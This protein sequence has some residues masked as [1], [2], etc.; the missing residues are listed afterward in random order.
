[1]Q[2]RTEIDGLRALAV[3]PVIFFHAGFN[4]F[5]GGF[6]GV[7]IFFVIS[8]YL[9]TNIILADIKDGKF[10]VVAFY[11][12]RARRILPAL[13]FVMAI[14]IPFAWILLTPFDLTS[15]SKSLIAVPLFL[16]NLFFWRDGGYFETAAELK[17][18]LHTWSLAVE[19][20]YY[21]FFPAFLI[22]ISRFGRRRAIGA[23]LLI[24]TLSLIAAQLS[25][26]YRPIANF[27]LLPTRSWELGIGALSA[28]YS[29]KQDLRP[30]SLFA[31]QVLSSLG[32][33]LIGVSIFLFNK[34]TP[35]PG[36]YILLPTLGA[37]LILIFGFLDTW[38]GK[39]LSTKLLVGVGLISY[40]VYLWHQPVFAFARF[41]F[42]S[43]Q[44]ILMLGLIAF[45]FLLSYVSWR[46]VERPFR[47][48][49]L[50]SRRFIFISSIVGSILF[51]V[52]GFSSYQLFGSTSVHSTEAKMAKALSTANVI[53]VSN[54]DERR[55]IKFRIEYENLSPKAI[56][57]GS[58]RIMQIG[59]NN[60]EKNTLNLGVSGASIEDDIAIA[61]MAVNKFNPTTIFIA[62]DPWLFNLKSGQLGWK[63]INNDYLI[64]LSKLENSNAI[65]YSNTESNMT[66]FSTFGSKIYDA[67]NIQSYTAYDDSPGTRDKIRRDGSRVYN[68]A[69]N[70]VTK[71][72]IDMGASEVLD[73]AMGNY[74]YSS[75]SEATFRKYLNA[76]SK[77]YR[78]VLILPPFHPSVYALMRRDRP[79]FLKIENDYRE[80]AKN[81]GIEII[82]SYD[83]NA[84]ECGSAEFYDGMHPKDTCMN[85]VL[86]QLKNTR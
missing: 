79:I 62:A 83:P 58:S 75:A 32:F 45:V 46:Y 72:E 77:N 31:R 3:I 71:K 65:N 36:F 73:Y 86:R 13:F 7:D 29:A 6:V 76:Y 70:E 44:D 78:V 2:Y 49:G 55:F 37:A 84:I 33:L 42:S 52:F 47:S 60:Y 41:Y 17:P 10:S 63:S 35:S 61:N 64:A 81:S 24:T 68:I 43:E 16:S 56:V 4:L 18:L 80:L 50:F 20:Q 40:S 30:T 57:L 28:F 27:F 11:E 53:Y 85:K 1:M 34:N 82:G 48:Q 23:I 8:G 14:C 15:F 5:G 26:L 39:L 12:R 74:E 54:M 38:T 25:S 67:I 21:I 69:H 9:I 51:I 66:L 19:E 22:F 59:A